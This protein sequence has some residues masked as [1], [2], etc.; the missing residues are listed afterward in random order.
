MIVNTT[1]TINKPIGTP[2]YVEIEHVGMSFK[3]K[4]DDFEALRDINLKI[5]KGE[6]ITLIGHSGCGKSTLLNL[7]AGLTMPS[8]GTMIANGRE[9]AGP[10]PERAVV[11]QNHSL[12]P[13]LTCFDNVHLAVER[14][15]GETESKAQLRERTEAT[16]KMVG[17]THALNKYPSEISGGMKQRVGIARAL[18]MEPQVLLLDEPFGALDALTRARLQD[19]L[20]DIVQK[21][22]ATVVMVTHDVDEAVLLS[23]R[24][25]MMTNGPAATIGE[26]LTVDLPHP[27]DRLLLANNPH[28]HHLRSS[29]LDFLYQKMKHPI[30]A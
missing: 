2:G 6:F 20:I 21:T 1:K 9:I 19:E 27:R 12:L 18:S 30:S 22:Q 24:V 28:Y 15:F 10:S 29:V 11:F 13:W 23:D 7:I 14:V 26:I 8:K 25:V 3:T 17:L 5:T 4:K 16:L